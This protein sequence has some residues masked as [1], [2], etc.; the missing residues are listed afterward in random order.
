M[1]CP[2]CGERYL[3]IYGAFAGSQKI[4]FGEDED[5]DLNVVDSEPTDFEWEDHDQAICL[6]CGHAGTAIEFTP[7]TGDGGPP[8]D[9]ATA[10]GMYDHD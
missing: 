10:T 9:A 6:E 5:D 3:Q 7:S 1:E 2:K 8:Y 4:D